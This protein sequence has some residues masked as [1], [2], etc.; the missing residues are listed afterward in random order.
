MTLYLYNLEP[1]F[2]YQT[3]LGIKGRVY[4]SNDPDLLIMYLYDNDDASEGSKPLKCSAI[5]N[6]GTDQRKYSIT[7]FW[8]FFLLFIYLIPQLFS[9]GIRAFISLLREE[10]VE[11]QHFKEMADHLGAKLTNCYQLEYLTT[12]IGEVGKGYGSK[13][14]EVG[15]SRIDVVTLFSHDEVT[16]DVTMSHYV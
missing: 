16:L 5:V 10:D 14:L 1:F 3:E 12:R 8:A 13:L 11:K 6:A 2:L 7:A 4:G 15:I 9:R